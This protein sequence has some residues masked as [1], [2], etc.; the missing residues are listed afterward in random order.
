M[1]RL[2]GALALILFLLAYG[3]FTV[4]LISVWC[5][6]AAV[7]SVIIYLHFTLRRPTLGGPVGAAS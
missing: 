1:V 7:L 2:F 5:F 4:T 6:F 3:F